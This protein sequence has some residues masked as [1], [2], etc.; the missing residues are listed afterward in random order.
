MGPAGCAPVAA[1]TASNAAPSSRRRSAAVAPPPRAPPPEAPGLAVRR[2]GPTSLLST[3]A[4]CRSRTSISR[5]RLASCTR[6]HR[7]RGYRAHWATACMHWLGF[8]HGANHASPGMRFMECAC[9]FGDRGRRTR[10]RRACSSSCVSWRH[11]ASALACSRS[12]DALRPPASDCAS[13]RP[14][15][16]A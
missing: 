3:V 7:A 9:R 5:L 2:R 1:S 13:S 12:A 16:A 10:C 15:P 14:A 8:E 6:V 4:V 11:S